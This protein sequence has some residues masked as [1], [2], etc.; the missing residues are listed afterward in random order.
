MA[1]VNK[2][3]KAL[4]KELDKER[5]EHTLGVM[6][7]AQCLA[8]AHGVDLEQAQLAGLLHDCA[9]CISNAQ[10]LTLCQENGIPVNS[11]E[12]ENPSLLHAKLGAFVARNEYDITDEAVLHAI[13]VH[14]TGEPDMSDLDK[15][16][17]IADYIEPLRNK[18]EHLTEIR[19]TAFHHLNEAL[20]MILRDTIAYLGKNKNADSIDPMTRETYE[21]YVG[22]T[23]DE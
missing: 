2:I 20:C 23:L 1:D 16:I 10:K 15:I 19:R 21:F 9:K 17:F 7:T 18:A 6:Y 13:A 4:K 11:C 22:G 14:T 3:K 12:K 5:F 8:M